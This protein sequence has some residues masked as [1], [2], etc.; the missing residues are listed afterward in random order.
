MQIEKLSS[1][2]EDQE[3]DMPD[4]YNSNFVELGMVKLLLE[5]MSHYALAEVKCN[6][7]RVLTFLANHRD[8][9]AYILKYNGLEKAMEMA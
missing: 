7:C 1:Y 8:C 5:D 9:K 2:H 6:M 3:F 4:K